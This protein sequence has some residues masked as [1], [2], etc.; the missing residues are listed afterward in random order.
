MPEDMRVYLV[1]WLLALALG[2]ALALK[3]RRRVSLLGA[4]YRRFLRVPWRLATFAIATAALVV[5]APYTGD[6]TWD[7]YDATFMAVLTFA[8]APWALGCL[9]RAL[10]GRRDPVEIYVAACAWMFS[11][12]WSYDLYYLV[13]FGFY[14]PS[15]LS[16]IGASAILYGAAGL[17]WNLDWRPGR[18]VTFAFLEPDWPSAS[19]GG[20]FTK[21]LGYAAA[22]MA[23]V[24]G[25][26][27]YVFLIR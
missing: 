10:R 18:G 15:W 7:Y 22:F 21:V 8:T 26:L 27:V 5:V 2:V 23:L 3:H 14:P 9:Y 20:P 1:A 25:S 19:A 12:S 24:T 13:R 6:P 16:N 4:A 11:T 17:F